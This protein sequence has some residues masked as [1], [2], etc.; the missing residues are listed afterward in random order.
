M[1]FLFSI[2]RDIICDAIRRKKFKKWL[3]FV[4]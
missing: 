4:I 3:K 1:K 2:K